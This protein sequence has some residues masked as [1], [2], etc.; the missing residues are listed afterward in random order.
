M[1]TFPWTS[2][3]FYINEFYADIFTAVKEAF[4]KTI[5]KNGLIV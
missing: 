3:A 5:N 1:N 4:Q 2:F